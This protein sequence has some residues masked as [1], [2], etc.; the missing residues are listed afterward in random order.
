MILTGKTDVLEEK[1]V[2]MTLYPP[3]TLH[4]HLLDQIRSGLHDD[5]SVTNCLSQHVLN[6]RM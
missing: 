4:E 2:P 3:Q 6:I 5:K 1:P